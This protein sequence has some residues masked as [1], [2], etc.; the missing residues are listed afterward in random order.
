MTSLVDRS[1]A[2]HLSI[3]N[4]PWIRLPKS[5]VIIDDNEIL[6]DQSSEKYE[7]SRLIEGN[8]RRHIYY[9]F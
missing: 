3:V 5:D 9:L 2:V 7:E 4:L 6:I 8:G 1:P